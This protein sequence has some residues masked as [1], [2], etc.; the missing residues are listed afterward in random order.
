MIHRS[1]LALAAGFCALA[2]TGGDWP[3]WRGPNR[4]DI[5][6]ETGLLKQWP[7]AGPPLRWTFTNAGAGYSGPAIVGDRLYIMGARGEMECVIAVD[8]NTA[9]EIWATRF[10]KCFR[11]DW[12]DGPRGTPTVDGNLVYGIGGQ[13]DLVCVETASG[14]KVWQVRIAKDLGGQIMRPSIWGYSESPLVDGD[15]VLCSPGGSKGTVACLDKKTGKVLWRSTELKDPASYSSLTMDEVGSKRQVVVTTG[16]GLAGLDSADGR[17]LWRYDR[18]EFTIA[19]IPTA[20]ETGDYIYS[21]AD[22]SA[23]SDLIK[24]TP[25]GGKFKAEK[26]YH[27]KEVDNKHGGMVLVGNHLYGYAEHGRGAW[28][29]EELKTGKVLWKEGQKL[30]RG[31]L[32]CADGRLYCYGEKKGTV[33]LL[34]PSAAGWKENGRFTIPQESKIRKPKG[35]IWTHPVVANGHL[36]LRDQ[37]L[38]FCYDLKSYLARK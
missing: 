33:V 19:V 8:A 13:G 27:N 12:G 26:V 18:P 37:D 31:S 16:Y 38:I 5:S 9:K 17:L 14:R 3:Q 6:T 21:T 24:V 36:Y 2:L 11:N 35:G 30:E 20:I 15:R 28:V 1:A 4:D 32:T 7:K 29:C 34:E 10:A 23:G 25:S 22:Y